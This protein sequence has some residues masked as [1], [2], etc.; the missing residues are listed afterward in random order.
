MGEAPA[1]HSA[2]VWLDPG[3][4]E[5][6]RAAADAAGITITHAGC[7]DP[8]R[9]RE[10]AAAL[11]CEPTDDLRSSLASTTA[12][13]LLLASPSGVGSAKAGASEAE[14]EALFACADR[15]VHVASLEPLPGSILHLPQDQSA[16]DDGGGGMGVALGPEP[17]E[18]PVTGGS[19]MEW[20]AFVPLARLSKPVRDAGEILAQLGP[21]SMVG[22]QALCG[23][24]QGSLGA[25]IYDAME[26]ITWLL[27]SPDRVDAAYVPPTAI[28]RGRAVHALPGD[29]LVGLEGDLSAN[30]RFA[31]GR[32]ASVVASNRAGRWNRTITVVG[33]RGRLRFYDDGL[34]WISPE[35]TVLDSSRDSARVR[36][37]AHTEAACATAARVLGDQIARLLSA[38]GGSPLDA[39]TN[40]GMV[41][42][43]AGAALLS[44]RTGE[45]ESPETLL[46]MAR[47]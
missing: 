46:R 13:M 23:P 17:S 7:P 14:V 10:I 22:V 36:G 1:Q 11:G 29:S 37:S 42:A 26:V 4:V 16:I 31:D 18:E 24:G 21:I 25:R 40:L 35:G 28:G 9:V 2:M 44:T 3:Q 20:A 33:E 19:A 47:G 6:V 32:A 41:L 15:G 34:D 30:L 43:T 39:P 8:G 45:S 12:D 27:G 38:G 5:L